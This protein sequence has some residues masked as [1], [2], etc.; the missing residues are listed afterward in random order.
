MV[1]NRPSNVKRH[2]RTGGDSKGAILS[3]V[4]HRGQVGNGDTR[5]E[6]VRYQTRAGEGVIHLQMMLSVPAQRADSVVETNPQGRK[7]ARQAVA[8]E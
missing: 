7:R 4:D 5:I 3:L 1:D 2:H 8:N 6:G